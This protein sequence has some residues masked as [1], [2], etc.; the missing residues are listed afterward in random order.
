[1]FENPYIV[2]FQLEGDLA[3]STFLCHHLCKDDRHVLVKSWSGVLCPGA[4]LIN[5]AAAAA[6]QMADEAS[7]MAT[8]ISHGSGSDPGVQPQQQDGAGAGAS[9]GGQV[10]EEEAHLL[11]QLKGRREAAEAV[12][13]ALSRAEQAASAAAT[14]S[15][16][17]RPR[18]AL[19][20]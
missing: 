1:M 4:R 7:R 8:V 5:N 13:L 9:S 17:L 20:L 10:T 15:G 12:F 6:E 14:A 16:A 11:A 18:P 2:P 19:L 3:P